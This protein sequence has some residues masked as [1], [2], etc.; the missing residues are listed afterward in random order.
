MKN[1]ASAADDASPNDSSSE[2]KRKRDD[3]DESS[4]R[5][6]RTRT[7]EPAPA[8]PPPPPPPPPAEDMPMEGEESG[9]TPMDDGSFG[10]STQSVEGHG[11][12]M[13]QINGLTSPMQLGT[14]SAN[15]TDES[16]VNDHSRVE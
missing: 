16:K 12:E 14:P 3:G 5:N 2:L 4:P 6:T 1:G 13:P 7:D 11:K 10:S 15:G 8:P 9:L